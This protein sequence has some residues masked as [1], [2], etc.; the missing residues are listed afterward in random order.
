[1]YVF[2]VQ[3]LVSEIKNDVKSG[4]HKNLFPNLLS[5]SGYF[6]LEPYEILAHDTVRDGKIRLHLVDSVHTF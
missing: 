5:V 4:F 1:M 2:F 6:I 3:S